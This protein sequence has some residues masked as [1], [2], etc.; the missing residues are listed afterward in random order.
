[1]RPAFSALLAIVGIAA[2]GHPL[3]AQDRPGAVPLATDALAFELAAIH[4]NKEL[5]PGQFA[6]QPGGRLTIV[7]LPLR[8]II[9]AS[10]QLQDFQIAGDPTWLRT[11]RFDIRA[12]AGRELPPIP[13]PPA[14]NAPGHPAFAMLR[15]LL[16]DRFA[17]RVHWEKREVAQFRLE[18]ARTDS[19]LGPQLS[20][21]DRDCQTIVA[22]RIAAIQ[23]GETLPPIAGEVRPCGLRAST[24][25]VVADSQSVEQIVSI[26]TSW[27]GRHIID[28]T[29]LTGLFS[30]TLEYDPSGPREPGA[31][32]ERTS[33]RPGLFTAVREQLGLRLQPVTAPLD[34]LVI[35]E[36]HPP[37]AN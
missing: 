23:R 4:E 27:A 28:G 24:G 30:F 18:L 29:G 5:S 36:I 22:E 14:F 15:R 34:V 8:E 19:R 17:L 9:R 12:S 1:M 32:L 31:A 25:R 13:P 7:N 3:D 6:T 10:F 37:T 26:L 35:D 21:S 33:E 16:E 20:R 11:T 2:L